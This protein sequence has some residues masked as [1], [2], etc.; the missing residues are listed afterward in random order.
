MA[1]S[2]R[3]LRASTAPSAEPKRCEAR[4]LTSTKT[5]VSRSRAMTSISPVGGAWSVGRQGFDVPLGRVSLV[6]GKTV[7]GIQAVEFDQ[8]AVTVDF[9]HN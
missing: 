4:A 8:E 2:V 9:G 6:F 1:R 3:R 7:L 5:M